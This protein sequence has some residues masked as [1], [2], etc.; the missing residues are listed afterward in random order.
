MW[1]AAELEAIGAAQL[2]LDHPLRLLV[3]A[4]ALAA[5]IALALYR[6]PLRVAVPAFGTGRALD[7]AALLSFSLRALAFAALAVALAGPVGF[8]PARAASG[9]GVDLVIALDASG[10]MDAL[11][12]MLEGQRATRLALAKRAVADLVRRRPRDRLGLIVFGDRA[13][14][15]C[16]LT[17]DHALLLAALERV[18]VGVAGDATAIGDALGLA[19]RRLEASAA[20]GPTRRVVVLLTDGRHNAGQLAPVTAARIALGASVRTHA[21][22]I[23]GSGVVPFASR[24]PGEPLRFEK[25]DLDRETLQEVARTT[26]GRFLHAR[27]PEDLAQVSD[28]IHALETSPKAPPGQLRRASLLPLALAAALALLGLE[29]LLASGPLRR[30]P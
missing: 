8:V 18:Q 4:L 22:G 29:A 19:V 14:T 20:A 7:G 27:R 1:P 5:G 23:G 13:F 3:A 12:G 24:T 11:D 10:S 26:G 21:V 30:L 2:A 25:V 6:G 16:P 28:V 17:M 15:Q 9:S